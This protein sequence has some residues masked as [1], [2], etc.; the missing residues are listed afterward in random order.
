MKPN[1]KLLF[2]LLLSVTL[3][4][5]SCADHTGGGNDYP[6]GKPGILL[7]YSELVDMLRHYD[8]TR[9]TVLTNARNGQEDARVQFISIDEL[10]KYIAYVERE[11]AKHEIKVTG[12]NFIMAAYPTD[13]KKVKKNADHQTLIMMPATKIGS[14]DNVSF[15]PK[16]SSSKSPM[17]L[18][19]ILE[20]YHGYDWPYD[21][22]PSNRSKNK[23]AKSAESK[24]GDELSSGGNRMRPSPP[25]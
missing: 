3:F 18:K 7:K 5:Y 14:Y 9:G 1:T 24:D 20:K 25:H 23:S 16:K 19:D 10:K 11:S 4:M 15:D 12:I 21:K 17:T 13:Y 8:S 6:Q 2:A 22:I